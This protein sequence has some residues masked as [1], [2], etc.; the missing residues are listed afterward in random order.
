MVWLCAR[1][2]DTNV[3]DLHVYA[4]KRDL[5]HVLCNFPV[6]RKRFVMLA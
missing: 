6:L 1:K 2:C 5:R 3:R 4:V